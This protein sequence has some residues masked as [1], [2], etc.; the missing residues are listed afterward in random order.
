[1]RFKKTRLKDWINPVK[2]ISF[3]VSLVTRFVYA[4]HIV[5]QYHMRYVRCQECIGLKSCK[6]CGCNMPA[7]ASVPFEKDSTDPED[8]YDEPRWGPIIFSKKKWE[9]VKNDYK[10]HF[11]FD[12]DNF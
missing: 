1:M 5:E 7:K 10:I 12:S 8:A 6:F 4:P 3:L 2:W 9:K 11:F